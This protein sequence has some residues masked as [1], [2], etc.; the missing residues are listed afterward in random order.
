MAKM[1]Y[2]PTATY[3]HDDQVRKFNMVEHLNDL[4]LLCQFG[5]IHTSPQQPNYL[6]LE[7]QKMWLNADVRGWRKKVK[8]GK[9]EL[10]PGNQREIKCLVDGVSKT[11]YT[12]CQSYPDGEGGVKQCFDANAQML[13]GWYC[14]GLTYFFPSKTNRDR[15]LEWM[16]K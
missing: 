7:D 10:I 9:I 8:A 4:K 6:L 1:I 11:F 5:N 15:V 13:F 3:V 2:T 14:D 16:Q 12:L